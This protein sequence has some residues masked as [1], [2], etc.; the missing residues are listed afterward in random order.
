L[1]IIS[2][3]A[4]SQNKKKHWSVN[5]FCG[6]NSPFCYIKKWQAKSLMELIGKNPQKSPN[7]EEE[8]YEMVKIF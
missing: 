1:W 5:F 4:T 2:T 3:L 6:K 8:S 7:F